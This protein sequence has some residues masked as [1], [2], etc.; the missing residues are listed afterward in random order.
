[1]AQTAHRS[2]P[3]PAMYWGIALFLAVVTALEVAVPYI[4]ALD[5]VRVP[6]LLI[7]G[8]IKFGTVVAFFMHLRYDKKLYRTLFLFGAI[9]V[10]PL[11]LVVLLT[12]NAL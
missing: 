2:H 11:F 12:M 10:I 6:L 5:P 7:M 3:T 4:S 1:M 9:G 8:A